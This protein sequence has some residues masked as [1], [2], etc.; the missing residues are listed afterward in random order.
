MKL[1]RTCDTI[2]NKVEFG[3][4]KASPDGLSPKCKLCQKK[5]DSARLKDPKRMKMRRDYQKTDNGKL[6]HS[7]AC[8]K[9]V[10]KNEIKRAAHIIVGNS[11]KSG[12]LVKKPCEVCG[13]DI[14]NAHHDDY[15][16]PLSVRWLCDVHHNEWHNENGEGLNAN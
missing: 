5:Y 16:H 14:V 4:R 13:E 3:N 1:C 10:K 11:I 8:R 9:W 7:K 12:V 15:A 2:K 6:A